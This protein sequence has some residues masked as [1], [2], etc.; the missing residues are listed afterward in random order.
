[1]SVES[2][3]WILGSV[4]LH[5]LWQGVFIGCLVFAG[6]HV[7][8]S[9]GARVRHAISLAGLL[10]FLVVVV[11]TFAWMVLDSRGGTASFAAAIADPAFGE[12][13]SS[14]YGGVLE[15]VAPRSI[16]SGRSLRY[17]VA[18]IWMA[19][20][21][22]LGL[23]LLI[24]WWRTRSL[25]TGGTC[26]LDTGWVR[27]FEAVRDRFGLDRRVRLLTSRLV[28]SPMVV[29]WL[30]PCVVVP[31]SIATSLTPD[32]FETILVHELLHIARRDHLI[33]MLQAFVEIVLF[34][35]P[36]TWWLSR[37]IRIERENCCDD[38]TIETGSSPRN[39]AEALLVLESLRVRTKSRQAV[40]AATGGLLMARIERLFGSSENVRT[41]RG[42]PLMSVCTVIAVGG[43][44]AGMPLIDTPGFAQEASDQR[45]GERRGG[46]D[47]ASQS[48]DDNLAKRQARLDAR[49]RMMREALGEQVAA[50]E[51]TAEEARA[52]YAEAE[53][54]MMNRVAAAKK[55]RAAPDAAKEAVDL[56]ELKS[57][58]DAR[59]KA[60]AESLKKQVAAG[61][62]SAE[63]SRERFMDAESR[64]LARYE[65]AEVAQA[66]AGGGDV[67]A[68]LEELRRTA[69]AR[70]QGYKEQLAERV[71]AGELTAE[72]AEAEYKAAEAKVQRRVR[73]AYAERMAQ[74]ERVGGKIDL[75][76]L[77]RG[78]EARLRKMKDGLD[79]KVDSGEMSEADAKAEYEAAE[80]Q[81]WTRYRAAEEKLAQEDADATVDLVTLKAGIESRLE[82][83]GAKLR[84]QVEAGALSESAARREYE[85]AEETMW[86]YYRAAEMKNGAIK[87][88]PKENAKQAER[89]AYA[90]A[91]KRLGEMVE[92]GEISR[93]AMEARLKRMWQAMDEE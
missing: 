15:A 87:D 14:S 46:A 81:M 76:E 28:D 25:R 55:E 70:L 77:K 31:A 2:L 85:N 41:T 34:F 48:V 71:E 7:L 23:R 56:E 40:L 80:R 66:K 12:S 89:D 58:I 26:D 37:Q 59:L 29:G 44:L 73:A 16:A 30:K 38:A 62:I 6:L 13:P 27:I 72:E 19:G 20:V 3:A 1:M 65:A 17:V 33:N 60:L 18:S 35:H 49:M 9:H 10:L 4:V 69:R 54:R 79:S 50:G 47:A 68:E 93:E 8:R 32:Q 61:E 43:L 67:M 57:K 64:M 53:K 92:A 63:E 91:A 74:G 5:A 75:A 52:R 78:I 11:G 42:W 86:R 39:L 82:E 84:K 45:T 90:A 51:I 88:R 21:L 24:Q 36:V 83:V 22:F